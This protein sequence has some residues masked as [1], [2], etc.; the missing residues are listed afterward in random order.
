L[1]ISNHSTTMQQAMFV[2]FFFLIVMILMSGLFTPVASMPKWAQAITVINP[3]KYF[4]E[5]MRAIFL[6][7][8]GIGELIPQMIAL[9]IFALGANLW[10][11]L[12]YKKTA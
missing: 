12:S 2:M 4:M 11:V 6:K 3:L 7:G 1:I 8:S 10:A 9:F 5:V